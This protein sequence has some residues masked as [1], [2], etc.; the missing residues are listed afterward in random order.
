VQLRWVEG[1]R[2]CKA[3]SRGLLRKVVEYGA[4]SY[5]KTGK[6][7]ER[8][9]TAWGRRIATLALILVAEMGFAQG[10]DAA[11]LQQRT[12]LSPRIASELNR[13]LSRARQGLGGN[14]NL[15]VI[16]QYKQA[17]K[18]AAL[19]RV[20]MQRRTDG[21]ETGPDQGGGLSVPSQCVGGPG[22]RSGGAVRETWII[23]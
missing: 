7:G 18:I 3:S 20:Q 23:R 9:H 6:S 1:R 15:E 5:W 8:R 21:G 11:E 12:Q 16:V 2:A 10:W 22:K 13:E 19:A 4:G 17:P 14:Q